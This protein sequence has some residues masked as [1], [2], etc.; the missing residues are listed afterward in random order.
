MSSV[1][2]EVASE[3]HIKYVNEILKTI[4]DATKVRGT[5]IAKRKPE[6]IEQKINEGKAII[7][8]DGD[9]FVGFCYIECWDHGKFVANSGLIVK[10]D[11]RGQGIAK[12]I[13]R[14]AFELSREKFP[15]AK[16]FG[17][18]TGAAVMKIN[19]E[20]GYVPVTFSDLTT[21]PTFWKGCESCVNYDILCRNDCTRCLCT[22]MLYD[23]AKHP[24]ANRK[25]VVVAYSGGLDTSFTIMYLT[26]EMGYDVYAACAN[27]GGFS[28]KQ[29]K[30]NEDRAYQLGA[31]KYV[32]LDVTGEYYEK[33]IK[34]M[35]YGNVL[36]N[37]TYPISVSSER[38]F[39][40]LAVARYAKEIG[41][42]AIAHGS[43]GAGNDQVRFDMTF[44][45]AAPD[46]EIITLTRDMNLSRK[47]EVDYLNKNG[48]KA[49]FTKLKYSYNVG[50]WGTSICG[51][52]ILDSKQG[53]P[54]SAYLKQV[55]KKGSEEI[56]L[57]FKAGVLV[58][59]NG[60]KF[61]DGV[62]AVQ[63]VEEIA[64]PYGVGRDMHVGDTIVGIKGR[65]GFEAAAPMLIIAA[66]KF[67][68]KFTL[69]KWQQY[70]KDQVANW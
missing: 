30:E 61:D 11:Y 65:V 68:E 43:T 29:L 3:K 56:S 66:H 8:M 14:K 58:G 49:D 1:K 64:A 42:Q 7:A 44:L 37:G 4:E 10:D 46:M 18:T 50:L 62:K 39:Q 2:V 9:K 19:T 23:P 36:R 6:Y 21:D 41:A 27:T 31:K 57:E 25:K 52:E 24:E 40:A 5:G 63:K 26:R 22:G 34:Y 67:L 28:P 53:L 55:T 17:L 48:F 15:D 16:I 20:L 38:I 47:E 35:V 32:T 59:V 70:W 45:V 60:E 12:R 51:G 69:S 54:E 13:K 33:S